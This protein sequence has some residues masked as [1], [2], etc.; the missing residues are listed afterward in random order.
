VVVQSSAGHLKPY[1]GS[2]FVRVPVSPRSVARIE[3]HADSACQYN[4][5]VTTSDCVRFPF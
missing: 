1:E 4:W 2:I 3:K 5:L